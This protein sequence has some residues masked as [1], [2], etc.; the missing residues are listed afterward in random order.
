MQRAERAV[1]GRTALRRQQDFLGIPRRLCIRAG[2]DR[3]ADLGG[4]GAQA[5]LQSSV[6]VLHAFI[7]KSWASLILRKL[8]SAALTASSPRLANRSG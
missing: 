4:G 7:R 1:V 8:A 3:V 2:A 5:K 6:E